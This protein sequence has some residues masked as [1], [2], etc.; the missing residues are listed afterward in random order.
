MTMM[1]RTLKPLIRTVLVAR[2][3]GLIEFAIAAGKMWTI[4]QP[5]QMDVVWSA[6]GKS[7]A[8]SQVSEPRVLQSFEKVRL[9]AEEACK[10]IDRI[11]ELLEE[12]ACGYCPSCGCDICNTAGCD[13]C[14]W[15]R[16][17]RKFLAERTGQTYQEPPLLPPDEINIR[18]ANLSADRLREVNREY[19]GAL[20][21]LW[22]EASGILGIAKDEIENAVGITNVRC[23]ENRL[24]EAQAVLAKY[25]EER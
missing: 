12:R 18:N 21:K 3:V 22:A 20:R 10:E 7:V 25:Q 19:R 5:A 13:S 16:K 17:A 23:L 8:M 6:A 4:T 2:N 9:A 14:T 11:R 1:P 15:M 24:D